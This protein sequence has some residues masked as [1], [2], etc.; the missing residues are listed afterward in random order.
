[1]E[2]VYF[3]VDKETYRAVYNALSGSLIT[4]ATY[5]DMEGTMPASMG[6][7][8]IITEWGWAAAD[9]PVIRYEKRGDKERFFLVSV[10]ETD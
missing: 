6:K 4:F 1:M 10:S 9:H 7:P 8:T 5:T 2:N 3:E